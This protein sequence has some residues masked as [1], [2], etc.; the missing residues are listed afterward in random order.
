MAGCDKGYLCD[1]CEEEVEDITESDLYLQYVLGEVD[2]GALL[3][4]PERHVRCH[5]ELAQFI[6]DKEFEP[7]VVEGPAGKDRLDPEER[8]KREEWVTRGWRR[9]QEVLEIGVGVD[10][11]PLEEV[12]LGS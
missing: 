12:R 3:I 11:Y 2:Q 6:V 5:P 8:K 9:L 10:E 7:V 1:V 4:S